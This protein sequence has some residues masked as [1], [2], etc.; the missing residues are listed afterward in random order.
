MKNI[1]FYSPHFG[2]NTLRFVRPLQTQGFNVIGLGQDSHDYIKNL[3]CF[4]EFFNVEEATNQ[5][6]LEQAITKIS[7]GRKIDR[8]LNIQETFQL[9]ISR[10]REKF[11]IDGIKPETAI[12][13]RDKALMKKI[14]KENGILCANYQKA[15]SNDE[16]RNF[17]SKSLFPFIIKPLKGVSCKSTYLVHNENEFE[18]V[19]NSFTI[20]PENSVILEE[21]IDGEEGSLDTFTIDGKI[22]FH[23]ITHYVPPLLH[24]LQNPWIQSICALDKTMDRTELDDVRQTGKR[25]IEALKL[26]TS[27]THLEWFRRKTDGKIYVGEIAARPA[28]GPVLDLH[29]FAHDVD[30]RAE[31]GNVMVNKRFDLKTERKF[32]VASVGLRAQGSGNKVLGISGID[33]VQ[34]KLGNLICGIEL[35]EIGSEKN[36]GYVGEGSLFV[37]CESYKQVLEAAVFAAENIKFYC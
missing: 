28:G 16:A 13:F 17:L 23:S 1:I 22:A 29:N 6:Q 32:S 34:K 14:F 37:R 30:L 35:P 12:K 24:V 3:R 4:N 31:W 2:E 8:L 11:G 21:F 19:L 15:E 36:D 33:F 9:L 10:L 25:V 20:S 26:D 27:I 5:N 7:Q 18:N